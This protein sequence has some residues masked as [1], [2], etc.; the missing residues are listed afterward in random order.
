[1]RRLEHLSTLCPSKFQVCGLH[2]ADRSH[3][4]EINYLYSTWKNP[5]VIFFCVLKSPDVILEHLEFSDFSVSSTTKNLWF[6]FQEKHKVLSFSHPA[7]FKSIVQNN[8]SSDK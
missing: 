6:S 5:H 8:L 2:T 1:M 3:S 4:L 7:D